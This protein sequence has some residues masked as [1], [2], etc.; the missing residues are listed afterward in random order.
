MAMYCGLKPFSYLLPPHFLFP[1]PY[2]SYVQLFREVRIMK[3]LDH[4]NIG[5]PTSETCTH[6]QHTH[7]THTAHIA[8]TH[9]THSTHSTHIAHT[10]STYGTHTAHTHSTY[11]QHTHSTLS[12]TLWF[13]VTVKLFE[14]IETEKTLY[15]VM[16]YASGGNWVGYVCVGGVYVQMYVVGG[17]GV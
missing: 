11:T 12:N 14:V 8:H 3:C 6:I 1:L 13:L 5:R 16:E 7:S 10:H 2:S 9:S 15:L 17:D 4:P